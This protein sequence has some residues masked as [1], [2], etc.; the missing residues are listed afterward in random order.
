MKKIALFTLVVLMICGCSEGGTE[1]DKQNPKEDTIELS[2]NKLS[3]DISREKQSIYVYSSRD[4]T[5][6]GGAPWCT[7]SQSDGKDWDEVT[8]MVMENNEKKERSTTFL[9]S[10]GTANET[11]IITQRHGEL[12]ISPSK[13]EMDATGG[14]AHIEVKT[15]ST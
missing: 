11:L 8:F 3:F 5:L 14:E 7:P 6:T 2:Q 4:W 10:C 1:I 12:I 15:L 13:I 9:F